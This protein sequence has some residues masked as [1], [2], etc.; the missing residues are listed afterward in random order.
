MSTPTTDLGLFR[1]TSPIHPIPVPRWPHTEWPL[2]WGVDSE[3]N[4]KVNTKST[5][6]LGNKT[7]VLHQST[8]GQ[9][10]RELL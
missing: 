6:G 3:S 9:A 10:L 2:V 7:P 1:F 4:E 5:S 8:G